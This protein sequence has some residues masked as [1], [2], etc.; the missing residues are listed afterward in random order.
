MKIS[1]H[2]TE[3]VYRRYAIVSEQ[4]IANAGARLEEASHDRSAL[5]TTTPTITVRD[6]RTN[7]KLLSS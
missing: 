4:D 7:A 2:K 3:A 1:G 6:Q 5:G